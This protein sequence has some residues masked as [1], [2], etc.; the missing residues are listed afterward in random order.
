[1]NIEISKLA[2]TEERIKILEEILYLSEVK[3][4]ETARKLNLS[5]GL[6]SKYFDIL[7]NEK[8]LKKKENIF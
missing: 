3:V 6:V 8:M 7:V 5:K 2:S 1:M 4:S